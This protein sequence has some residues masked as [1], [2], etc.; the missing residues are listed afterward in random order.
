MRVRW[1]D[2]KFFVEV[3]VN[4]ATGVISAAHNYGTFG[5]FLVEIVA[6][7]DEGD[8]ASASINALVN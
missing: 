5:V 1:G 3:T 7:T 4:Q 6:T 2:S 8:S